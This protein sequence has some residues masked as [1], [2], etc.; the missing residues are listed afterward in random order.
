MR[1][2]LTH[3]DSSFGLLDKCVKTKLER[4]LTGRVLESKGDVD[5]VKDLLAK[6][7][8]RIEAFLVSGV[9]ALMA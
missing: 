4:G 7:S 2:D 1:T 3:L 8:M 6:I 9:A 5:D